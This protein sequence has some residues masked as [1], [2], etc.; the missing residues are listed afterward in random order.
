M[1][2]KY[3]YMYVTD[4]KYELPIAVADTMT[5]LAHMLGK[6]VSCVHSSF[7][8]GYRTYKKVVID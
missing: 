6:S 2:H 1:K 7:S 8:K 4:D 5:E 3:L